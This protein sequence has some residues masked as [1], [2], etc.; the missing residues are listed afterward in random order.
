MTGPAE[1]TIDTARCVGSGNCEFWAPNV[2]EVG[3]DGVAVVIGD[4]DLD[5]GSAVIA[6]QNCPTGA[7]HVDGPS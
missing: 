2:F 1:V 6:A 4:P 7:I 3:P 5:P